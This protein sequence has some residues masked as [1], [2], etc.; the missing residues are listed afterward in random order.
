M[1]YKYSIFSSDS[2]EWTV[3][4]EMKNKPLNCMTLNIEKYESYNLEI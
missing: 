3:K 4:I 1:A 2:N